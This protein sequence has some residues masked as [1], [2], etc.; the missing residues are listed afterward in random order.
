[1]GLETYLKFREIFEHFKVKY[2]IVH[3]YWLQYFG[4]IRKHI[5]NKKSLSIRERKTN[6]IAYTNRKRA[7]LSKNKTNKVCNGKLNNNVISA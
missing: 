5:S 3:L 6:E 4:P 2:F 1:M 7:I